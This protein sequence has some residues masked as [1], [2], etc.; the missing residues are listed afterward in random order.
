M[1]E[2]KMPKFQA[3]EYLQQAQ[4]WRDFKNEFQYYLIASG[5]DTAG[6]ERKVGILLYCMGKEYQKIVETFQLSEQQKKVFDTVT[7]KFDNY[8]EPRRLK[9]SYITNF[10]ARKQKPHETMSQFI[11]DLREI[12]NQCEFGDQLDTQLCV[13]ITNGVHNQRL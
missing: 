5:K 11:A 8:F 9:K 7:S 4:N 10:Q 6:G 13:Q 12:A 3:G 1:A 2:M